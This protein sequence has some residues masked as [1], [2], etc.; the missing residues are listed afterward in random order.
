MITRCLENE[1]EQL[2]PLDVDKETGRSY[3][4]MVDEE[5][6]RHMRE[7]ES[8]RKIQER[9]DALHWQNINSI[10]Q[11]FGHQPRWSTSRNVKLTK[12]QKQQLK[13]RVKKW[14]KRLR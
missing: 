3:F 2:D 7:L 14:A 13:D 12:K 4:D 10:L 1:E 5:N 11:H 9:E 6:G 8:I